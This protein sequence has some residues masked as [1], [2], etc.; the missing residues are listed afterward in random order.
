MMFI[1]R[2]I[3]L[4][5]LGFLA[6]IPLYAQEN[7]QIHIIPQWK[8]H[9][10][11]YNGFKL[12]PTPVLPS[13]ET[14]PSLWFKAGDEPSIRSRKDQDTVASALWARMNE[15][16]YLLMELPPVPRQ[17]DSVKTIHVYYG[18][19][20]QIAFINAFM[21][22]LEEDPAKA[23]QFQQCAVAALMRGYEGPIYTFDPI[24]KS[25]PVDEIYRAIWNQNLAAAYDMMQDRLTPDEDTAIRKWMIHEAEVLYENLY[26]WGEAVHN[27]L[28]KP[29][30]GLGSLALVLSREPA[31]AQWL[32]RAIEA[33]NYNTAYFFSA[34]GIYREGSLY[35]LFSIL[36]YFPFLVHYNNVSGVDCFSIFQSA[37]EWPLRIRNGRGWMPNIEDSFIRPFPSQL[38]AQYYKGVKT[39][40]S[41]SADL[42]AVL[43]WNFENTDYTPF[44]QAEREYGYNYTGATWDYPMDFIEYLA[45]DPSVQAVAPNVSPTVFLEGG[46]TVFRNDWSFN[47]PEHR[48]L[49]FQGVPEADNHQHFDHLSFIIQ[50]ENQL[51]AEDCGYTRSLYRDPQ[52]RGWYVQPQAHNTVTINGFPL[53]DVMPNQTPISRYRLDSGF[54]DFEEKQAP[55]D[56]SAGLVKRAIAFPGQSYFVVADR[57]TAI[58]PGNIEIYLHGGRGY[59]TGDGLKRTWVFPENVYGPAAKMEAF[60]VGQNLSVRDEL[61]ETTQIKGDWGRFPYVTLSTKATEAVIM[62]ILVPLAASETAPVFKDLSNPEVQAC[63][64]T[65]DTYTDLIASQM[66]SVHFELNE[67]STDATFLWWRSLKDG[68]W[69]G[70]RESRTVIHAGKR[71]MI[72]D[73]PITAAIEWSGIGSLTLSLEIEKPTRILLGWVGDTAPSQVWVN[74]DSVSFNYTDQCISVDLPASARSVIIE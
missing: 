44:E 48:Y 52:R 30:W 8:P 57:I 4:R 55:A 39:A 41:D 14:H 12:D 13:V 18:A 35:Y 72:S 45:Y 46:Q 33:A 67:L 29:A 11:T 73:E 3:L 42:A 59:S 66:R 49:L 54:F 40:L 28:S 6:I 22:R 31:A 64:L 10:A 50:A 61:G 21:A 7:A 68:W 53:V 62:Q 17:T 34:D 16:P 38:F 26:A 25:G 9:Y 60:F 20:S 23:A 32:K 56:D 70:V 19:V 27:H 69:L 65:F 37:T 24:V 71:L 15:S 5:A 58:E 74:G 1:H 47:D 36:N 51:M 2:S 43:Q 63:Q